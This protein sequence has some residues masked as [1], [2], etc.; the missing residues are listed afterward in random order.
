MRLQERFLGR[1]RTGFDELEL[2]LRRAADDL[3]RAIDVGD[4]RQLHEDLVIRGA[5]GRDVRLGDAQLV[6]PPIDGFA[7]L[8]DGLV[9]H[10]LLDVRL[11]REFVG[12]TG[13][14]GAI[15]LRGGLFLGDAAELGIAILRHTLD[16]EGLFRCQGNRRYVHAGRPQRFAQLFARRRGVDPERVPGMDPHDEMDAAFEIQAELQLLGLQ[17]AGRR[18]TG[19]AAPVS[20]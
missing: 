16:L 10:V 5:V 19:S 12:A 3:L 18:Q 8:H 20:G 2:E 9:P 14:R 13:T 17:P 15:V 1:R 11:H 7:R 6:H 4:A